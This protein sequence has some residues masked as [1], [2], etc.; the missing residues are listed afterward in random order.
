MYIAFQQ[1]VSAY[2]CALSCGSAL[3]QRHVRQ[4]AS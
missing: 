4:R 1:E 2:D 3:L